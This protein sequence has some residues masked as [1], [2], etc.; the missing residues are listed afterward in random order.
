[1][2]DLIIEFVNEH[3]AAAVFLLVIGLFEVPMLTLA[4]IITL[5]ILA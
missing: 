3:L 4:F 1:M 2:V 5:A